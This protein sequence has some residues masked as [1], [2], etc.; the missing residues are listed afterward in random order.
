MV[1]L[2]SAFPILDSKFQE[3]GLHENFT[4]FV[5]PVSTSILRHSW[6]SIRVI[7]PT[8]IVNQT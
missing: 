4:T 3:C 5:S 6:H 8:F 7:T 2:L 1:I